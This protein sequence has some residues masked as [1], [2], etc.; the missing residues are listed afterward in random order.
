MPPASSPATSCED[1]PVVDAPHR[2]AASR[3][4]LHPA[5]V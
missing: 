2:L 3:A 4:A 1:L 5:R